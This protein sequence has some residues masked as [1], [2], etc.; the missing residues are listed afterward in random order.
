MARH[1]H[2]S[3]LSPL[4]L[5][6]IGGINYGY[7]IMNAE[8]LSNRTILFTIDRTHIESCGIG[9]LETVVVTGGYLPFGRGSTVVVYNTSGMVE[10]LPDL[11]TPR[12]EH[13]CGYYVDSNNQVVSCGQATYLLC[14]KWKIRH[15]FQVYLVTG[16]LMPY[17]PNPLYSIETDST[18]LL[19]QGAAQWT[20]AA[21]LPT[22]RYGL[23]G[24]TINNNIVVTGGDIDCFCMSVITS[25]RVFLAARAAQ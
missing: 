9:L 10:Q 24:A 13:A 14:Q 4:G 1:S 3:W 5:V 25:Y 19:V 11:R 16:G 6:L 2:I 8:L 18:E 21:A 12:K 23:A 7:A 15:I 20:L 17:A 22:P